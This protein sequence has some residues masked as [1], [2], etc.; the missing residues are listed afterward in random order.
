MKKLLT[1]TLALA[2]VAGIPVSANAAPAAAKKTEKTTKK[3]KKGKN[4][5]ADTTLKPAD[6]LAAFIKPNA[7]RTDGLFTVFRQDDKYYFLIPGSMTGRDM[8]VVNR[9]SK[10]AADLRQGFYGYAGDPINQAMVRFVL[11]PDKKKIFI[12]EVSTQEMPRDTLGD[13]YNAVMRSNLQ[14][15]VAAFDVKAT[16]AD[17]LLID[18]TDYIN[19]DS[20]LAAFNARVKS[21][22]N[23]T[24]FQKERSYI[25]SVHGYPENIEM[26]SVKS[27]TVTPRS[28]AAPG[29]A[30]AS[31]QRSV[32]ATYEINSSLVLLPQVPMQAR[33]ADSRVGYF[34]NRYVDYDLNPQ[35]IKNVAMI[36]RWR[37]EPKPEDVDR[38]KRG[39]LVEPAKPIVFYIDPATPKKWVP[40]LIAGV[41][42]WQDAF[43][44]AGF[45]NAIIGK[46]APTPDQDPSWS[47]E[48]ARYSAIVYMPS[49]I[50]NA[51]GPHINDP[52]S[53]EIM[54]SHVHWYHNIMLLLR[55]WYIIQAGAVDPGARKLT[56]DEKLMGE[57]IRFVSSHEV[58][59]ALGLRHNF[60]SS[61][62][63]PTDSLRSRTFLE[64][65]GHTSSI[66]D[67][68]RF[69][70]VAQPE[71]NIPRELLFPRIGDYDKWAIEW[72]YRRFPDLTTPQSEEAKLNQWII[73]K[74][75]NPRLWFGHETN[76]SDPRSQ[77]EDL[78]DNQMRSNEL[79]IRNLKRVLDGLP[80]WTRVPNE[81]YQELA[82]L[83]TEVVGQFNR[84]NGH[85]AKWIGGVY[86]TPKS[87]EQP[88]AVYTPV[89]KSRQQEAFAFLDAQLFNTPQWLLRPD[90][91]DKINRKGT[92]VMLLLH[93]ATLSRLLTTRVL[94]NLNNAEITLGAQNTYTMTDLF[95]DFNKSIWKELNNGTSP[96][97]YRR[98]LQRAYVDQLATLMP[99][100]NAA[101]E[102]SEVP[103]RVMHEL[104]LLQRKL[105]S[106]YP[107][108]PAISSHYLYLRKRIADILDPQK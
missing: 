58:G 53:G 12:E 72:G 95:N 88:G 60:G 105:D 61:A 1:L 52:R 7:V 103:G 39:E 33:Y 90:I 87:V 47:L 57:L 68:A 73:E 28:A 78:G 36:T 76:Q 102:N 66:M 80:E 31:Q 37:L 67:Y 89:E 64:K 20:P 26:K 45:K 17:S 6:P 14:P 77:N 41:N 18:V 9:I 69:N 11:S 2:L 70:Y 91:F 4:T 46:E 34:T 94:N 106:A 83:Y 48:D 84:Y 23:L 25:V 55:N 19:G 22:Y 15:L 43:E 29:T 75:A 62:M 81:G 8:L 98:A 40:Y 51:M 59:H 35:G 54:E 104:R 63:T 3:T 97:V 16:K 38:Y 92:D 79:G 56:F 71:D 44:K 42:D 99:R 13:M 32:P 101:P 74:S 86:E 65:Y 96:D 93:R 49:N 30:A 100:P 5:V 27:Y 24:A 10:A 107:K 85:V 108:D 82:T 21:N 50:P